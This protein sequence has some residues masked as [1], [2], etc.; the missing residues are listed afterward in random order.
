ME[1]TKGESSVK[2]CSCGFPQSYPMPHEHDLTDREK[3][4]IAHK[5][6]VISDMREA[7]RKLSNIS[8]NTDDENYEELQPILED[9][10][11]ALAKAEK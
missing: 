10:G 3:Q 5:D 9:I 6:K 8:F 4:I 11:E 7:L 1:C 2:L